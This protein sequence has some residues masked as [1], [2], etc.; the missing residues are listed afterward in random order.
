MVQWPLMATPGL[1]PILLQDV[2]LSTIGGG[3]RL[4]HLSVGTSRRS[5][6]I[7]IHS[8]YYSIVSAIQRLIG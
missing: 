8:Y 5:L 3:T 7:I 6:E 1:E 2:Y 4:R